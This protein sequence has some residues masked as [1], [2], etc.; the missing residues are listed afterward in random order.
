[1]WLFY[2]FNFKRNY[3]FL[4][5]KGP[6]I[7]LSENRNRK[8]KISNAVL[9]KRTLCFCSYKNRKPIVKLGWVGARHRKKM[10][11]FVAF[12]LFERNFFNIF[13][14]SQ[15]ILHWIH[16]QNIRTLTYQKTLLHKLFYLFLKS[17]KVFS[18]S[19]K[20]I[21]QYILQAAH[22]NFDDSMQ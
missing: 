13:V 4:K 21:G 15:C 8:W 1:M 2:Y 12:L 9:E 22:T 3:D 7:L 11:F 18:V 10:L 14:L 17:S 5:S 16:S 6:C 20:W 19:L